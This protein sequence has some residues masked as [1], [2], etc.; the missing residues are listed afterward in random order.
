MLGVMGCF[1]SRVEKHPTPRTP[2]SLLL[3]RR[4][5]ERRH[6]FAYRGSRGPDDSPST[7]HHFDPLREYRGVEW[8]QPV[9]QEEWE[10]RVYVELNLATDLR[11]EGK[12]ARP[13]SPE[14]HACRRR[15]SRRYRLPN[16]FAVLTGPVRDIFW[17]LLVWRECM[18][19]APRIRS[20]RSAHIRTCHICASDGRH[21]CQWS[22]GD[23]LQCKNPAMCQGYRQLGWLPNTYRIGEASQPGPSICSVNPGGWS[24]VEPVLNLKHDV[25]AV[26]ETFVLR[27]K[28]SSAKFIANKLGYYSSF[29]PARKTEGRP[30]G[31]LALLC[32]RAQPLQ[33]MEKGMHWELGRWAHHLL[34]YDGGLHIFNVYGYSSDKERAPELNREVCL[35]IFAAVAAL[36]NR[37]IFILGDWNFEPDNFP[38]DLVHGGQINRPLSEVTHTSPTGELQI[39]WMLCS[40]ALMPACGIEQDTGK[41]PDH[42]AISMEFQL[43]LVSQGYRGQR[44]YE[45]AERTE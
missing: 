22:Q 4:V 7:N 5:A 45:T 30:S 42:V 34:P 31:G 44:S 6:I 37:Q 9:P 43:E 33:R 21:A 18:S 26:Q 8:G 14:C 16:A 29:T 19:C 12:G 40:K 35:E 13:G 32:R 10:R 17:S 25:V 28:V 1:E 3:Q 24:L 27:D 36:G 38:I 23:R 41:K 2:W 20:W 11:D 15:G 39:D